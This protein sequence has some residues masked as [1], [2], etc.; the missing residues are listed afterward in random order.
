MSKTN[1]VCLFEVAGDGT[2]CGRCAVALNEHAW[3]D[4]ATIVTSRTERTSI[5]IHYEVLAENEDATMNVGD[6]GDGRS[7]VVWDR[8][9]FFG[10]TDSHCS[11]GPAFREAAR[12]QDAVA[13][14]VAAAIRQG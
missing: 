7:L 13:E 12:E 2:R 5:G 14:R 1:G 9:V 4:W 8:E 10:Q 6:F 3:P 11:G